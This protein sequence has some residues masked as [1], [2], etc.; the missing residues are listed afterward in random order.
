MVKL[1]TRGKIIVAIVIIASI[2]L[3]AKAI[4]RE[5]KIEKEIKAAKSMKA[6]A[7]EKSPA[8]VIQLRSLEGNLLKDEE[9]IQTVA[10]VVKTE[11]IAPVQVEEPE[12]EAFKAH[13]E[14]PLA[15]EYQEWIESECDRLGVCKAYAYAL[16]ES[17][18]S[19]RPGI[20][21]EDGGGH[22]AGLCQ[23]NSVNWPDMEDKGLDP[24][25]TFD[26]ITYCL[27]LVSKYI[28]KYA[29]ADDLI[30]TVTTCY[31]AGEYGAKKLNYHLSSCE[32]IK[33][34]MAYY[35]VILYGKE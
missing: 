33:E 23:I 13:E 2:A 34:R 24:F 26:N 5:V 12:E 31:K 19:F 29:D 16:I 8:E 18:S 1:S 14:I 6:E 10:A 25:D 21:V 7:L 27:M 17:E 30:N 3:P 4:I 15:E 20:L 28:D 32:H 11:K 9:P 22:S 35:S